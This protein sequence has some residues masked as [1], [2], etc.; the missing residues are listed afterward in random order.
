MTW[1]IQSLTLTSK[2]QVLSACPR[3]KQIQVVYS[4]PQMEEMWYLYCHLPW[5]CRYKCLMCL[6]V[7]R[8]EH[9][10]LSTCSHIFA[11]VSLFFL[12][13]LSLFIIFYHFLSLFITFYHFFIIFYHFCVY[14]L[15]FKIL[16]K[17]IPTNLETKIGFLSIC[18]N[19]DFCETTMD[20]PCF[21]MNKNIIAIRVFPK[22]MVPP[23]HQF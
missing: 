17:L 15:V 8:A 5:S 9:V 3:M 21:A 20:Y 6:T 7:W 19:L 18:G 14:H 2:K 12:K 23:N 13:F 1:I 22:I 4:I 16:S 11:S 10:S